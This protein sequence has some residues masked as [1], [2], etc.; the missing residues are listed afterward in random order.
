MT[1]AT[2]TGNTKGTKLPPEP[3]ERDEINALMAACSNRA[4]S[5]IRNRALLAV[6][7]RGMLRINEAL[8]LKPADFNATTGT[9]RVLDGKGRK[10]RTVALNAE[11]AALV[12]RWLDCRER[13]GITNH[14]RLFCTLDGGPMQDS[15]IRNMLPRLARRATIQ[16]RVHAHGLRHSGACEMRRAGVDIGIISKALG[17]A[18]IATTARYLDHIE[19]T[20]VIDAMR[21]L[22]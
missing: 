3:L 4:P 12:A 10:A 15:Y 9:V 11:A 5:G 14:R 19:P 18:S 21:S 22:A 13:R 2:H 16:K 1:T 17:H 7:W 20:L 8:Q 6:L